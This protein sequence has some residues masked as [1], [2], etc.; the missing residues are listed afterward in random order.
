[1]SLNSD[2]ISINSDFKGSFKST[3]N[4]IKKDYM[5]YL[6]GFLTLEVFKIYIEFSCITK[7]S[8]FYNSENEY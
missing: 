7:V 1:M 3:R 2:N 5:N 4:N 6:N 8:I